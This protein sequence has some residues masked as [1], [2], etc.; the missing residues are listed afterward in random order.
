M[1]WLK[2][3][4][5]GGHFVYIGKLCLLTVTNS[6]FLSDKPVL[7]FN[8][9]SQIIYIIFCSVNR[10][11]VPYR[12]MDAF[13]DEYFIFYEWTCNEQNVINKSCFSKATL[14]ILRKP[15]IMTHGYQY[16]NMHNENKLWYQIKNKSGKKYDIIKVKDVLVQVHVAVLWKRS[17]VHW[18]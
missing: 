1:T 8:S 18:R 12:V 3:N 15:F 13:Y 2:K 16:K 9:L 6:Y 5:S 17:A 11:H 14:I 10:L 7:S 4:R